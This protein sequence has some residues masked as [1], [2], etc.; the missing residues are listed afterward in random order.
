MRTD[1]DPERRLGRN[2]RPD[3]ADR[4]DEPHHSPSV[5]SFPL[6][7]RPAPRTADDPDDGDPGPSAA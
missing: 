4:H 1:E 2:D 7:P 3:R 5:V 6:R